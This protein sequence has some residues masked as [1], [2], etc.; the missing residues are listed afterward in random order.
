MKSLSKL[1]R[2][3][4]KHLILII[5]CLWHLYDFLIITLSFNCDVKSTNNIPSRQDGLRVYIAGQF[6]NGADL[7]KTR[8]SPQIIDLVRYFGQD[9]VYISIYGSAS[10]DGAEEALKALKNDLLDRRIQHTI[11]QDPETHAEAVERE[12]RG[13]GWLTL[14]N[15][16]RVLRRIPYLANIRN[17]VME[18]LKTLEKQGILFDVVLFAG[19]VEFTVSSSPFLHQIIYD[20]YIYIAKQI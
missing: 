4:F 18:P 5:F 11:I 20:S 3:K 13:Q 10:F 14:S 2:G 8:W 15:G 19:D 12:S 9:N 1:I 6:W 16:E 7:I 17:K